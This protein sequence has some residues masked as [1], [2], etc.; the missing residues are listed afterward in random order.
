[1]GIVHRLV[2]CGIVLAAS[3]A[4]SQQSKRPIYQNP[5]APVP[6]R[7]RDLLGRMTLNEK[8]AQLQS[9]WTLPSSL[10]PRP[11]VF[12]KDHLDEALAKQMLGNGLG[13][14][15]FLDEFLS[16]NAGGPR[17]GAGR[18]NQLQNWVMKNTRLGIPVMFHGEALQQKVVRR[19]H[20]QL[21]WAA[22]GTRIC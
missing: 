9:Q 2:V 18:R 5:E 17:E 20:R 16:M 1:M 3:V 19:F 21:V 4:W 8:V 12:D 6:E 13:T 22:R 10:M 14:F 7:V 11:S 15:A